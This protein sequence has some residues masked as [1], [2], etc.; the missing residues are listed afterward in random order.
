VLLAEEYGNVL[1]KRL[2]A[3]CNA[4]A[5]GVDVAAATHLV[6]MMMVMMVMMVMILM[7]I[8]ATS[9]HMPYISHLQILIHNQAVLVDL[10]SGQLF[11]QLLCEGPRCHA[12]SP[13]TCS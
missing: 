10:S 12:S 1:E 3:A 2:V 13:H 6:V 8:I 4:V 5:D 9:H 7:M 11:D